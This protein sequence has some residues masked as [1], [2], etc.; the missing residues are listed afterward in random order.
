MALFVAVAVVEVAPALQC[1][2]AVLPRIMEVERAVTAVPFA[3]VGVTGTVA[4]FVVLFRR[5]LSYQAAGLHFSRRSDVST[6]PTGEIV[7][8]NVA[9]QAIECLWTHTVEIGCL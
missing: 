3:L 6:D 4:K 8:Q 9:Q 7:V 2:R 5:T 1:S